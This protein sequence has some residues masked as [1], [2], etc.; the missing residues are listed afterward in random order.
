VGRSDGGDYAVSNEHGA[1]SNGADGSHLAA[2]ARTVIT[3]QRQELP[4]IV[5]EQRF[6]QDWR[7]EISTQAGQTNIG[8]VMTS[9]GEVKARQGVALW[10]TSDAASMK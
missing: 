5:D 7:H 2:P 8:T 4:A 9:P 3:P 6:I 1:I 10:L